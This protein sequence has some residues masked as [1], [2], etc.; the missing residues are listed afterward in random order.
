[1]RRWLLKKDDAVALEEI[2][3]LNEAELLCTPRG[4]VLL[5]PGER[6]VFALNAEIERRLADERRAFWSSTPK[7]EALA[8]VRKL[9]GIQSREQIGEPDFEEA[10]RVDRAEYHIDKFILRTRSGVPLPGLAAD[11]APGGPIEALVKQGYV[12]VA[13]D[14]RGIGETAGAR[15][16]ALL[17]DWKNYYLAYLL[18]DSLVGLRAERSRH[19][20]RL[21]SNRTCLPR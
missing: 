1:M 10:G 6:S 16:D 3:T 2:K 14:L 13:I 19:C 4:Q 12:V 15:P 7:D 21:P 5:L 8:E 17:G 9:A 18:G 20:T 11:G